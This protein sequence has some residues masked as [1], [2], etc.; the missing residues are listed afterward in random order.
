MSGGSSRRTQL[1]FN[2]FGSSWPVH[3][4]V[5]SRKWICMC[6][7]IIAHSV[8]PNSKKTVRE[9]RE[10][11]KGNRTRGRID[12]AVAGEAGSVDRAQEGGNRDYCI[13]LRNTRHRTTSL[14]EIANS[15]VQGISI[16]A[17]KYQIPS[18]RSGFIQCSDSSSSHH[19]RPQLPHLLP[20]EK[21]CLRT[22]RSLGCCLQQEREH[23]A[24]SRSAQISQTVI[25]LGYTSSW[26]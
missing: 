4:H 19:G 5:L 6:L 15:A 16:L 21:F 20:Q 24:A 26:D 3:S 22:A 2:L 8:L 12:C 9:L 25:C 1:L 18:P 14:E 13:E 17:E 23:L 7:C 10:L 11:W